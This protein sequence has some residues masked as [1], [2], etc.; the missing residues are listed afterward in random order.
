MVQPITCL[1]LASSYKDQEGQSKNLWPS[2]GS[3]AKCCTLFTSWS[4][5]VSGA[6][7]VVDS[8]ILSV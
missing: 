8:G 3:A 7:Q 1:K 5:A 6:E 2:P 4:P